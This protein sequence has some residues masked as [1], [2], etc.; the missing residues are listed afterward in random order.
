MAL[1]HGLPRFI[2]CF[3]HIVPALHIHSST[4]LPNRR[5]NS[6]TRE[7]A[8]SSEEFEQIVEGH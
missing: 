3:W 2:R 8:I 6:D 7:P 5:F 4:I 1:A